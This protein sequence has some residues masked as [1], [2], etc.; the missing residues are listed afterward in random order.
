MANGEAVNGNRGPWWVEVIRTVGPTAAIAIFLV[1]ILA[2]QVTPALDSIKGFMG[3]HVQQMQTMIDN[4]NKE[5]DIEAKQWADL[6]QISDREHAD[7]EKS[8]AVSEQTCINAA[9]SPYQTQQCL[10]ARNQGEAQ[11]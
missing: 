4:V 6:K 7:R 1:Y 3:Q 10:N 11:P 2:A 5:A 9:K 8:L